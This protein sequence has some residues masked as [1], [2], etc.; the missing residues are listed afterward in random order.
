MAV[1]LDIIQL[2]P[3]GACYVSPLSP[4]PFAMNS[5]LF[6]N[7]WE[8]SFLPHR[9]KRTEIRALPLITNRQF[10]VSRSLTSYSRLHPS[11][12]VLVATSH[13]DTLAPMPPR[14]N[15][16]GA[17]YMAQSHRIFFS[18]GGTWPTVKN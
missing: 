16:S 11:H 3:S 1:P 2:H 14:L 9:F 15:S 10:P 5:L 18:G 17:F 4:S 8:L 13:H 12:K 6:Q 7:G